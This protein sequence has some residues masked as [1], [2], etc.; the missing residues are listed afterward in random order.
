MIT[1]NVRCVFVSGSVG[2]LDEIQQFLE[3]HQ[4]DT[5]RIRRK[6]TAEELIVSKVDSVLRF[7]SL[8][9]DGATWFFARKERKL[10]ALLEYRAKCAAQRRRIS[11][12]H[13]P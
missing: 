2:L 6:S 3:E 9:Y 8:L 12:T 13:R 11:V 4:I 7:R 5:R 1:L 10:A